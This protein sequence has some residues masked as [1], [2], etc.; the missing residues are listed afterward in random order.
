MSTETAS[1]TPYALISTLSNANIH[2][3]DKQVL[4]VRGIYRHNAQSP[5]YNDRYYYDKLKDE[6]DGKYLTLKVPK[7]LRPRLKDNTPYELE[8]TIDRKID[9]RNELNIY[10][11]LHLT[12]IVSEE[13]PMIDETMWERADIMR[14]RHAKP[15]QNIDTLLRAIFK[16]G[17]SPKVAM[18][19]GRGAVTNSDVVMSAEGQYDNYV[20]EKVQISLSNKAEIIDTL[21]R[22]DEARTFDL[23]AIFRGGGSGLEIFD[24]HDIARTI[25]EMRTPIVT[26]IGHA[27]DTPF[28]ESVADQ[29]FITPSALGTYLKETAK[30]TIQ[31]V[32][33]LKQYYEKRDQD[34]QT[35]ETLRGE[36]DSLQKENNTLQK[37]NNTLLKE[38]A[39]Q[40]RIK[41][42][43]LLGGL[44]VGILGGLCIAYFLRPFDKNASITTPAGQSVVP[45]V[46]QQPAAGAPTLNSNARNGNSRGRK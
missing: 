7:A 2:P 46:N 35:I 13:A 38:R 41:T 1:L 10:L 39:A 25:I 27:E 42:L 30:T 28:I 15:R 5:L 24:D 6:A 8:G 3:L 18:V 40:P 32:S 21:W 17:K 31:E 29:S 44:L 45:A 16:K 19:Y 20:I 14:D 11:S 22:L 12:R 26:G 43:I 36:K 33:W 34:K 37:E 9:I 23:I 4:R